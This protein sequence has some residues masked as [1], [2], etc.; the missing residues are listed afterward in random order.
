MKSYYFYTNGD[1][2]KEAISYVKAS[3]V[4]EATE[5]FAKIKQMPISVFLNIFTV[6]G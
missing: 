6:S 5:Y 1:K 3:S 2:N 4:E